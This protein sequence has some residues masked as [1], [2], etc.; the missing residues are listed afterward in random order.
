METHMVTLEYDV[1]HLSNSIEDILKYLMYGMDTNPP[2][3]AS[4]D[5]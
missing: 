1:H 2:N 4:V 3:H 5:L